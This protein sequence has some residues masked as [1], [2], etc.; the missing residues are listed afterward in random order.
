MSP[1][2]LKEMILSMWL[3]LSDRVLHGPFSDGGPVT[4]N[5][6]LM[7]P[8]EVVP[9]PDKILSINRSFREKG[10]LMRKKP[11]NLAGFGWVEKMALVRIGFSDYLP[12]GSQ[13]WLKINVLNSGQNKRVLETGFFGILR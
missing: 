4:G 12:A 13:W 10:V 9:T 6:S 2:A 8:V 11:C 1:Y 3:S 7:P 5:F